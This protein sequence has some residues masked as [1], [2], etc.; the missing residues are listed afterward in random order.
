VLVVLLLI[1]FAII[2]FGRLLFAVQGMKSAS[3]EAARNVVV[4]AGTGATA[5]EAA[6]NAGASAASLAGGTLAL[7]GTSST[8][9]QYSLTSADPLVNTYTHLQL[10]PTKGGAVKMTASTAFRWFTPAG[11]FASNVNTVTADTTMRCE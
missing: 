1:I 5:Y 8:S 3:R 6:L 9:G 4:T 2:D 11:I 7:T 10:C